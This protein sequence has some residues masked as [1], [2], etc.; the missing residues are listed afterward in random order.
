MMGSAR[1]NSTVATAHVLKR[2]NQSFSQQIKGRR[3]V[4]ESVR[5]TM[6]IQTMFAESNLS[7]TQFVERLGQDYDF[8]LFWSVGAQT[9]APPLYISKDTRSHFTK[10]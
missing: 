8:S 6:E 3:E 5:Q 9:I 2:F 10:S 7:L 1:V 4:D